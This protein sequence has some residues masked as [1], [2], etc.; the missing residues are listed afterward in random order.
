[1]LTL[2]VAKHVSKKLAVSF[3]EQSVPRKLAPFSQP[4]P[5]KKPVTGSDWFFV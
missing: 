5:I 2:S 1:M 3:A 4:K